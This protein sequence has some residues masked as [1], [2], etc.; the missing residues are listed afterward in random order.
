MILVGEYCITR[1]LDRG[2]GVGVECLL[3][4]GRAKIIGRTMKL[5]APSSGLG[6]D[7]HA[8][9]GIGRGGR[10]INVYFG[11]TVVRGGFI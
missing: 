4:L 6:I 7:G 11:D 8:T 2:S 3:A 10:G 9:D 1:P 5:A